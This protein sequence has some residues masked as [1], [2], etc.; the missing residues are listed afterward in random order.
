MKRATREG[1]HHGFNHDDERALAAAA[2]L[3]LP[4][5]VIEYLN[6]FEA[7]WNA[8]ERSGALEAGIR[9]ILFEFGTICSAPARANGPRR[10]VMPP[11]CVFTYL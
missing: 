11:K 7:E 1:P 4:L 6:A 5:H 10:N 8:P 3:G 9:R 2:R